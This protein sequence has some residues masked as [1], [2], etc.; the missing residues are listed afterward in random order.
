MVKLFISYEIMLQKKSC[1][2]VNAAGRIRTYAKFSQ[3]G[4]LGTSVSQCSPANAI[5]RLEAVADFRFVFIS[6]NICYGVTTP[7]TIN[8]NTSKTQL[9]GHPGLNRG[10]LDLQSNA[11]PL[12]YTPVIQIRLRLFPATY[13]SFFYQHIPYLPSYSSLLWQIG[14]SVDILTT[15]DYL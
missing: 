7:S 6:L 3:V 4:N 1:I 13:L 10:P 2:F 12:S 15:P 11:L 14:I 5:A 8:I 9:R